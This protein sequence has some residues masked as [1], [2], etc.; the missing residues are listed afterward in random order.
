[1]E[2]Q[3]NLVIASDLA[4]YDLKEELYKRFKAKG[5][6]IVNYGCDS[7]QNGAF[8][9]YAEKLA[10]AV[11]EKEF[12]RGILICGTGQ[13]VAMA[14]NKVK[15]ARCALCY[16]NF[17]AIMAREHNDAKIIATGAWMIKPDDAEAM[18]ECF[19]FGKHPIVDFR[20]ATIKGL[21]DI[22]NRN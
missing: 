21:E 7:S 6:N 19:L 11:V 2:K 5:Y 22:E 20:E 15:G 3:L 9:V 1:M 12:D 13:G 14:A 18:I 4:G 10:K 8:T 16:S 17:A